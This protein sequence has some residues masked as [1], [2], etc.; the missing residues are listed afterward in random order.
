M[1][2]NNP[3]RPGGWRG[4]FAVADI[5]RFDSDPS[6]KYLFVN[7]RFTEQLR[8]P[9]PTLALSVFIGHLEEN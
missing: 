6:L 5:R 7:K 3:R 1:R 4:F 2:S 8:S 9:K